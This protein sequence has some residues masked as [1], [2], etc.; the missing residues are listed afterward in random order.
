MTKKKRLLLARFYRVE[1]KYK[2]ARNLAS[3]LWR[4]KQKAERA[5]H[6]TL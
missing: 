5:Y 3:K 6:E 1:A 2:K 4:A